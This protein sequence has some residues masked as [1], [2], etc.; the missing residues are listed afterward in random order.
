MTRR[1]AAG[2]G[3]S[4]RSSSAP[5]SSPSSPHGSSCN[6]QRSQHLQ[7]WTEWLV[8]LATALQRRSLFRGSLDAISICPAL[9]DAGGDE[10]L[11]QSDDE[12]LFARTCSGERIPWYTGNH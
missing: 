7:S 10:G 3:C 5:V 4:A 8:R 11:L 2:R 9:G 1:A 6:L 12:N